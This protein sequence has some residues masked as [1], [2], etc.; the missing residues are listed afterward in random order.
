MVSSAVGGI[1]QVVEHDRSGLLF[2]S[3]KEAALAN[4]LSRLLD[5]PQL[6]AELGAA[7][8]AR[9]FSQ[10]SLQRMAD[11]YEHQYHA[12]LAAS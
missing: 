7:G 9:V 11:G 6:A 3:G 12:A 8:K 10:Y 1:P 4:A 2:E 5:R